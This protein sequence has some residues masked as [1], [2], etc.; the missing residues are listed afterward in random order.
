MILRKETETFLWNHL[1]LLLS[2]IHHKNEWYSVRR[3]K[4]KMTYIFVNVLLNKNEWYSV[5]R[6]KL[7]QFHT[8][9][10]IFQFLYHKNEW[11]SVR[12]RKPFCPVLSLIDTC[13]NKNEWYSVRRRKLKLTIHIVLNVSNKNE[14]YSV[15]RR[16]PFPLFW[17]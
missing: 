4:L 10:L 12:R 1:I 6:R 9:L 5:R 14:W 2:C 17:R 13:N 11:Y 7:F 3:R 16:K 8:T 15:R